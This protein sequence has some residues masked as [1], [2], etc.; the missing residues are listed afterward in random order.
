MGAIAR[1][2]VFERAH[3]CEGRQRGSEGASQARMS[4]CL[5]VVDSGRE[6]GADRQAQEHRR[7]IARAPLLGGAH[8]PVEVLGA[9]LVDV[10]EAGGG[11][12]GGS[13]TAAQFLQLCQATLFLPFVF[14]AAPS[15]STERIAEVID[16]AT[17]MF[18]A[19]YK[20]RPQ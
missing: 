18:L 20:A 9:P 5:V 8:E 1:P 6:R 12:D 15:P 7:A 19:V 13:I 11:R 3:G 10:F 2:H 16:S 14:Q 17:R 4:S